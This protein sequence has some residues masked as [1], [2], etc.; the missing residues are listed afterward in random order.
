MTCIALL[1]RPLDGPKTLLVN[2]RWVRLM[3]RLPVI[4]VI[5]CLPVIRGMNGPWWIGATVLLLYPLF[6][7][8]WVSGLETGWKFIESKGGEE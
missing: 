6:L 1:N 5:V 4:V 2:S 7:Y 8:E 3:F